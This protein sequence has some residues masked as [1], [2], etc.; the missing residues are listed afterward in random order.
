[1]RIRQDNE[2]ILIHDIEQDSD[3]WLLEFR[4][5]GVGSS[6][7]ILLF[8][9]EGSFGRNVFG[10]WKDRLGYE[11]FETVSNEHIKRGK[12]LEPIIRDKV[13][14]MLGTNFQ[15]QCFSRKS[16]PHLRASLDGFDLDKDILLEIK[17]PAEKMFEKM[18][19]EGV[20]K[21][22][23]YQIQYQLLVSGG[24][25]AL[26][27]FYNESRPDPYLIT[28]ENDIELQFEIEKR[29]KLFWE[30]IE[31]KIPIGFFGNHL[32]L[33]PVRP[34]IIISD[35]YYNKDLLPNIS[36]PKTVKGS[37][38]LTNTDPMAERLMREL[39]PYHQICRI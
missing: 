28:I 6:D 5:N 19:K 34:S 27:A 18:L 15:P 12:A 4:P 22:Y 7:I 35:G 25:Y 31:H 2:D 17:A 33:Y 37:V 16:Q 21:Y 8:E 36:V 39:N 32:K 20:P 11:K 13:N 38:V 14:E 10:L 1:M 23:Y 9:P 29:C 24:E 3:E 30:A 26:Y